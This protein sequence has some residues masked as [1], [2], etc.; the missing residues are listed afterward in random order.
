MSNTNSQ[1]GTPIEGAVALVTGGHRGF[2]CA[3]VDELLERGA[4]KV[5]AT[6]CP[7]QPQR[8]AR[9][10]PLVLDVSND[11]SVTAAA[12]AAPDVSIIVNNAGILLNKP[13][14]DAPLDDVR[15]ELETNL[16]GIIRVARAFAP[17]LACHPSSAMV[18]VL[19][20]L[21]WLAFGRG[22]EISKAAAWSATNSLRVGLRDQ[23]TIVTAL[24][25]GYMDTEMA[26]SVTAPKADPRDVAAQT[27]DAIIAGEFEILA[28]DTTRTVKSQLSEDVTALYAQL[29]A[30]MNATAWPQPSGSAPRNPL[31]AQAAAR[32]IARAAAGCKT[33]AAGG[34]QGANLVCVRTCLLRDGRIAWGGIVGFFCGRPG[35]QQGE[36]LGGAGAGLGGV[37]DDR[38]P[39]VG[40]DLQ[41]VEV[42]LQLSDDRVVEPFHALGVQ[43]DAVGGPQRPELIA[44]RGEFADEV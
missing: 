18:N 24:H 32:S 7:P 35:G 9:V 31:R 33:A 22:Y 2:G 6:S 17:V 44:S 15:A 12:E 38:E 3:M 10:V 11:R 4:A 20:V 28:D 25:V 16:F 42:E 5:Y 26:A 34:R 43:S 27:A 21:S 13:V 1:P 23:G 29:A 19:S 37:G 30:R 8:D 41:T 14:L 40:E 39:G 36:G